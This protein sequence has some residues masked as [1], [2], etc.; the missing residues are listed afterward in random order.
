[1]NR[2]FISLL[3]IG[4]A[5]GTSCAQPMLP[6]DEAVSVALKNNFDILVAHN[7]A[8]IAK[9]NNTP[10]NAGMLPSV[11]A[12]GSEEF[13]QT[14]T[15]TKFVNPTS[16]DTV[17]NAQANTASATVALAWT[18]FDGG[19]M[20]VTKRK[21][22]ELE[23]LG[24]IQFRQKV[25][26]T[27]YSVSVAYYDVVRQKQQLVSIREVIAYNQEQVKILQ[28][29]FGA[30]LS[31]KTSLLQA[32]IDLNVFK[33]NALAQESVI[34][35]AK[36]ALNVLLA[37]NPD[38]SFEVVDSIPLTYVPDRDR[39]M[40]Q[41]SS[42]NVDIAAF[43]KQVEVARLSLEEA[44]SL[45]FPRLLFSA[46]YGVSRIDNTHTS[47]TTPSWSWGY[48]P[49]VGGTLT[50]PLYQAGNVVRQVKAARLSLESSK[51][52]L[53]SEKQLVASQLSSA[54]DEFENQRGLLAI[55]KANDALA[56]E[57][58]DISME[59]LRLGQST[60]L[61]LRQ[62]QESFEDSRTRLINIEFNLKA[63]ETKLRQLTAEL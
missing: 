61:E 57:N 52:A 55:E 27:A 8:Q 56:K 58:L 46:G 31:P 19:K 11:A 41:V 22:G 42:S 24:A 10:G 38:T 18:L 43:Q 35:D 39:L 44:R 53:E 3:F 9:V 12:N 45:F 13:S 17:P 4:L 29:S 7:D 59:R 26:Q 5:I 48:G 21:L 34:R 51:D 14:S 36:R 54:L 6:A 33:E 20:F 47:P 30:G 32:Q 25:L 2:I 23:K 50:I 62:A 16:I 15:L 49:Q 40:A 28:T 63:A 60:S 1:M 37:R